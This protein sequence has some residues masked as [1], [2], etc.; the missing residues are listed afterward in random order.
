V[1]EVGVAYTIAD[2]PLDTAQQFRHAMSGFR[3]VTGRGSRLV[4][5]GMPMAKLVQRLR[6][7]TRVQPA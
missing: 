7:N 3:L 5:L 4:R 2:A 1:L 6:G